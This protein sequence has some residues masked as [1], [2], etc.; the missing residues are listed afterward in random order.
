M[1]LEITE[2]SGGI[3][4]LAADGLGFDPILLGDQCRGI[5]FELAEL[6]GECHVLLVGHRLIAEAQHEVVEPGGANRVAVGDAQGLADVD[7]GDVGAKPGCERTDGDAHGRYSAASS[8]S[9]P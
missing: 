2:I 1:M 5:E 7:A 6:A 8:A 3:S 9:I 4:A